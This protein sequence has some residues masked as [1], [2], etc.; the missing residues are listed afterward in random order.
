MRT[1]LL[2]LV[3]VLLFSSTGVFASGLAIPEQ[4]AAA[5]GMSA[6]MTARSEDLSAIFYNP[7][8]I[9][10]MHSQFDIFGNRTNWIADISYNA[11][12]LVINAGIWGN[13]GISFI[14]TDYGNVMGTRVAETEKGFEETGQLDGGSFAAGVS[15]ARELTDK[16]AVGGQIKYTA[17]NLGENLLEVGGE[18]I[19]NKVSGFA[20]DLGTIFYP[21]FKSF[22]LGMVIRNFSPQFKYEETPFQLPLT[23]YLGFAMDILD[24]FGE[25][26]EYSF[27]MDIDAIH[28][29][30]YT[31]RL[32]VGGEFWYKN[33]LAV[34][35]GYKFN[36]DEEDFTVG[37]GMHVGG[38]KLD[39]AYGNFGVFNAVNRVSFGISF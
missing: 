30:D 17:Q 37:V 19:E 21:G 7:A 28:P 18:P 22:R 2:V 20:Y 9:A 14:S 15:Y 6:A 4:G 29:R 26:P 23:F 1:T 33:M 24:F 35:G 25:H 31:E 3:G 10:K 27:V 34:R 5:M 11:A 12:G 13:F 32:H 36:Y 39:Y 38:I 8:G 16:F